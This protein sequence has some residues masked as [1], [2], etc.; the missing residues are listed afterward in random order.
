M[1]KLDLILD[2][3][4]E[5]KQIVTN[6]RKEQEVTNARLDR[7][8]KRLDRMDRRL[9]TMESR[10]EKMEKQH[11][12]TNERLIGIEQRLNDTATK[13]DVEYLARKLGEHELELDRL[14]RAK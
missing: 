5:L 11:E 14:K 1:D 2:S 3:L 12:I 8:E 6:M 4:G 9:E 7:M 13:E 10:Q